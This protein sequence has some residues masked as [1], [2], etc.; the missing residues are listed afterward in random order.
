[1]TRDERIKKVAE[2]LQRAETMYQGHQMSN[3]YGLTALE[4]TE[5]LVRWQIIEQSYFAL[6]RELELLVREKVQDEMKEKLK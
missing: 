4:R 5:A 1:M 6:K 3:T 2:E